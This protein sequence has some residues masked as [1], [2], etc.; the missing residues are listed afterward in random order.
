MPHEDVLVTLGVDTHADVHVVVALDQLGRFLDALEIPTTR[1]GYR[2]LLAWAGEF[3]IIDQVGIEGTGSYGAGLT[4]FLRAEGIAVVEVNRPDRRV[5]R[6]KGT[7]DLVDA[8]AAARAV[9]SGRAAVE[10]KTYDG[11]VEM[12]RV[13]RVT[14]RSAQKTVNQTGNQLL[15]MIGSAP[16]DLREQ[17]A[18][19]TTLQKARMA[20]RLRPGVEPDTVTT[21]TKLALKKPAQRFLTAREEIREID[22]HIARLVKATAPALLERPGVGPQTAA[23]L[24][25]TAGD[26][27][28]RLKSEGAFAQ[29]TG[30]APLPAS[31]GKVVRHRLNRGGD[32]QANW[33]LHMIAITRCSH[34]DRTRAYVEKRTPDGKADL[35]TLRRIKRYIAREIFKVL[36]DSLATPNHHRQEL[37]EA[38]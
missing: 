17:F 34:D 32:R 4:R 16:E 3:G 24:L 28:D 6:H 31:S 35:D 25:V 5:R 19:L 9:Q 12:L 37:P 18:G 13:L 30:T 29:L 22:P 8:E 1:S 27:P 7:S 20:S 36:R 14:R 38:A 2:Q 15:A 33:A 26:N 11:N 10:P 21:A 23:V